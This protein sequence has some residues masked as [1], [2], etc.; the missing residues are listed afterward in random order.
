MD[1]PQSVSHADIHT[2]P[3]TQRAKVRYAWLKWHTNYIH[4]LHTSKLTSSISSITLAAQASQFHH[5]L[6]CFLHGPCWTCVSVLDK[7]LKADSTSQSD[8]ISWESDTDVL[9]RHR[10]LRL[11][12]ECI[13]SLSTSVQLGCVDFEGAR[14]S[15][16][17]F[18]QTPPVVGQPSK[19]GECWEFDFIAEKNWYF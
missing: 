18:Q 6:C 19:L 11:S 9:P 1:L 14:P 2:F 16:P 12:C 15:W 8:Y 3:Q 17:V 4:L 7:H 5:T 13:V 10:Q